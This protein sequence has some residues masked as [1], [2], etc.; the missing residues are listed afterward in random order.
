MRVRREMLGMSQ[1]RLARHLGLT[2][3][4]VQKYEKGANRI[5]AGRLYLIADLLMV[6]V[7]YFFE[8]L[9][10]DRSR[11]PISGAQGTD[12]DLTALTAAFLSISD[13]QLR[14]SVLALVRSL[15]SSGVAAMGHSRIQG[16]GHCAA[17]RLDPP[18][19]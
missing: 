11:R 12:A 14:N 15:T 17:R 8:G 3:S 2:F 19:A 4:Q 1:G 6:P 18:A 7:Q 13:P 10:D 9:D 16:E 5:G